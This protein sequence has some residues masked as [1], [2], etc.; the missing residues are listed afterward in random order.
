MKRYLT[1]IPRWLSDLNKLNIHVYM[2]SH[3]IPPS[4]N[5][6]II[7]FKLHSII[8]LTCV[9]VLGL[10]PSALSLLLLFSCSFW[11]CINSLGWVLVSCDPYLCLPSA[12]FVFPSLCCRTVCEFPVVF[13]RF[14]SRYAFWHHWSRD[15]IQPNQASRHFW[16]SVLF[17]WIHAPELQLET[18]RGNEQVAFFFFN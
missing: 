3:I 15:S 7:F 4:R 2:T 12:L 5:C 16:S 8:N 9:I 14:V 17:F 10:W 13:C 11:F 6:I 18:E 1:F